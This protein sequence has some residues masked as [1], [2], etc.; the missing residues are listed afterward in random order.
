M[1]CFCNHYNYNKESNKLCGDLKP[2]TA[3]YSETIGDKEEL[4][5]GYWVAKEEIYGVVNYPMFSF[6]NGGNF[7]SSTSPSLGQRSSWEKISELEYKITTS[8]YLESK[9]EYSDPQTSFFIIDPSTNTAT[10]KF[11]RF[12]GKNASSTWYYKGKVFSTY[13]KSEAEIL[14]PVSVT[15]K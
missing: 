11:T 3:K 15:A 10:Y 8:V 13:K 14:S 1:F 5:V 9:K 12:N 6:F 7:K 2:I 4:V